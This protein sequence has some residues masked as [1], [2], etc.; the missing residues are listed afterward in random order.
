MLNYVLRITKKNLVF[1][2]RSSE[3]WYALGRCYV[4]HADDYLSWSAEEIREN[5]GLIAGFQKRAYLC[6]VQASLYLSRSGPDGTNPDV[7]NFWYDYGMLIYMMTTRPMFSA[8]F[9]EIVRPWRRSIPPPPP[10]PTA[11]S[12]EREEEGA[13]RVQ[14]CALGMEA[15]SESCDVGVEKERFAT[16]RRCFARAARGNGRDWRFVSYEKTK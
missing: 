7:S 14:F 3:A 16:A 1:N 4:A 12:K 8:G 10:P 9:E 6:F 2:S 15:S 5:F 11:M 13:S